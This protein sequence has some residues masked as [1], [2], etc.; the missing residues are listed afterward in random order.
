MKFFPEKKEW[1][2]YFVCIAVTT[3]MT[4]INLYF[5]EKSPA[6]FVMF[7]SIEHALNMGFWTF[8]VFFAAKKLN[9]EKHNI[10]ILGLVHFLFSFF[11]AVAIE[12]TSYLV[13]FYSTHNQELITRVFAMSHWKIYSTMVVYLSVVLFYYTYQ[14]T[15]KF[16]AQKEMEKDLRLMLSNAQLETLK[17]QLN[18]HFLFNTLNSIY[19]L[20]SSEPKLARDMLLLTSDYLRFTLS[21]RD[22]VKILLKDELEQI[23]R[24]LEIESIRFKDRIHFKIINSCAEN[25][26]IL[27]LLLQPLIENAI[28][29]GVAKRRDA[30]EILIECAKVEN[31]ISIHI[32]NQIDKNTESIGTKFGLENTE[33]RLKLTYAQ[34]KFV[35]EIN[36]G[37]NVYITYLDNSK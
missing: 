25:T 8:L 19:A 7:S 34:Y 2:I 35:T 9:I 29:H 5:F 13:I 27:S 6:I 22:K 36:N 21:I 33:K 26:E 32:Y 12:Y 23:H 11:Y 24:Y 16:I 15:T 17:Y 18:P 31:K 14:Y 28:K 30:T 1:T 20:I 4:A 10:W 37:F 3:L